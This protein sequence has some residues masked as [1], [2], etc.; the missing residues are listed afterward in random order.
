[1][2]FVTHAGA[3]VWYDVV[4]D[5]VPLVLTGGYGLMHRQF[6]FVTPVLARRYRVI[7]WN[8]RGAGLSDR[9][10]PAPFTLD[11]W[12][13]DL[14]AVL[15]HLGVRSA[16]LLG[17]S[18]GGMFCIRAA[19]R[20]PGLARKLVLS[21]GFASQAGPRLNRMQDVI[22]G[23][24]ETV[25]FDGF[26]VLV[27]LMDSADANQ[28]AGRAAE[29]SRFVADALKANLTPAALGK[30]MAVFN[31]VDLTTDLANLRQPVA[32]LIGESG[33]AA[34]SKPFMQQAVANFRSVCPHAELITIP[35]AG[36]TFTVVEQPEATAVALAR[37][38]DA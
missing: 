27:Q 14:Y 28:M 26:A 1:M 12:V 21:P 35:D 6:D 13:D 24:V 22:L 5:G 38:L 16:H 31:Q 4:G 33:R 7:N 10:W 23:L 2:P 3:K 32:L 17:L 20:R 8:H 11:D 15:D 19:A 9:N 18:Y 30:L 37:F 29:Q 25:G 36:G 34:A